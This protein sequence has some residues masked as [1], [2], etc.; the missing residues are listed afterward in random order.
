MWGLVIRTLLA[1]SLELYFACWVSVQYYYK[2]END[3]LTTN[4][5]FEF[6]IAIIFFIIL[7]LMP[8]WLIYFYCKNFDKMKDEED[9]EFKKKFGEAYADL[10]IN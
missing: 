2:H 3:K 5:K 6:W 4:E 1:G 9:T 8:I 10:R 7:L